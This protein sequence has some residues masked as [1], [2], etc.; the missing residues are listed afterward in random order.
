MRE[1]WTKVAEES[2][3]FHYH[4]N[5]HDDDD[6]DDGMEEDDLKSGKSQRPPQ[7]VQLRRNP[8]LDLHARYAPHDEQCCRL[9][10]PFPFWFRKNN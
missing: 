8:S 9:F 3:T 10:R 1:Q 7:W 6:D 4:N 2:D 5:D